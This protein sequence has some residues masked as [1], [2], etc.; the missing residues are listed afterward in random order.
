MEGYPLVSSFLCDLRVLMVACPHGGVTGVCFYRASGRSFR[1]ASTPAT[2]GGLGACES[3]RWYTTDGCGAPST[4]R[5]M[6]WC[7]RGARSSGS[8][9]QAGDCVP[10]LTT[11]SGLSPR[12]LR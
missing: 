5:W 3:L 12:L 2:R 7:E 6:L 11:A 9:I 1:P 10:A 4:T 8:V